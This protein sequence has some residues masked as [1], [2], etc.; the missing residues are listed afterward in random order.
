MANAGYNYTFPQFR[1]I[2]LQHSPLSRCGGRASCGE[3]HGME[4]M[5][6]RVSYTADLV[7]CM[8]LR[9]F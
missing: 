3:P 6:S 1:T 8:F 7:F 4:G 2:M 9:A 5:A